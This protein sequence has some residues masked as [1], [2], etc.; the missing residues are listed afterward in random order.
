MSSSR[1]T[2]IRSLHDLGGAAWFGGSLMGVVALNGAA[3]DISDPTQRARIA[4]NGWA[5]WSPAVVVAIAAHL[6]GGAG[7]SLVHHDRIRD[8][9][10]VGAN[11]LAKTTLTAAALAT[12]AYSGVLGAKVAKDGDAHTESSTKPSEHTPPDVA[13][14][15]QQLRV[16]QW[17]TPVLT[18]ALVVLGALH[19]EQQRPAE[20]LRGLGKKATQRTSDLLDS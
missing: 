14:A 10:G 1:N 3:G 4:A 18:G 20:R 8:Q 12:T 15:Q 19:G 6:V 13:K 7:L 5:R 2:F 9:S 17:A 16:L 11:T